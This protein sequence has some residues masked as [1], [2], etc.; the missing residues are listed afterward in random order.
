MDHISVCICTYKRPDLLRHL[1]AGLKDQVMEGAFSFSAVVVDNDVDRS[2]RAAFL[3]LPEEQTIPV[4][5]QVEPERNIS[6]ARN[7]SIEN[8]RGNLIAFIDDDE[9]PEQD[10]LL[11]HYRALRASRA[12][13]VLGP[14]RPLYGQQTPA[15]LKKSKLLER[16]GFLT[17]TIMTD[18]RDTR[19]GNVLFQKSVFTDRADWFDPKFGKSG[20]GDAVFFKR[21]MEKGRTFIWCD[22][23]VVSEAVPLERQKR[24]Y[25]LKR[26]MTRGLVEAQQSRFWSSNTLRSFVAIPLYALILPF[27]L[28]R[29]QH[30]FMKYLVKECDHLAKVLAHFGIK[31]AKERPY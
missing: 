17:G 6:L 29:G 14:V 13:G 19:T 4:T 7:R 9:Y 5:Y 30:L 16:R 15:W 11:N 24:S 22:E 27:T 25:Y 12:D 20:G 10:W 2:G 26:A 18:Y 28:L 31:L 23:A 21:M 1:L 8:A 3:A